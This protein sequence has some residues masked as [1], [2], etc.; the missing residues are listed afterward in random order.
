V[1]KGTVVERLLATVPKLKRSV[2]FTTREKRPMEVEG[3]DYFFRTPEEFKRLISEN[4][5]LEWAEFAGGLYATPH[6]W[7]TEQLKQGIDVILEIEV[8]GAKQ[9]KTKVSEAVLVFLSPPSFEALEDRLRNR[10]TETPEKLALR[11]AKAKQELTEKQLFHYEVVN[12]VV[13][14]AVNNLV[15]IVYSERCRI[16]PLR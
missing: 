9:V 11:L 15:H 13:D 6:L 3:V 2:S 4:A 5:F 1:G 8:Q 14:E 12:D 7:V 16:K 10:A